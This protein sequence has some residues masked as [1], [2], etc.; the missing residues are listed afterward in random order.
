[1]GF[2]WQNCG[3]SSD[4][5]QIKSLAVTPDPI[6]LPGN[7]TIDVLIGVVS[8]LPTDIH[9][10]V[11]MERKVGGFFIKIP[12]IDNVGSCNYGDICQVWAQ[13]CPK[14][15][16]K[17]GI[18][19]NCPIP[20]NTYSVPDAVI[21]ITGNIP[22]ILSGEFRITADIGSSAGHLGCLKIDVNLKT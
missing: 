11:T 12:C 1:L 16:A 17:Y 10:S 14:Y 2:S 22:S 13:A 7:I 20:A 8:Q 6:L 5:V 3:P 4:P 21:G 9:V 15:F 18:P 19:C